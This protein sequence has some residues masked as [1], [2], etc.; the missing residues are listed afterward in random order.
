MRVLDALSTFQPAIPG[1]DAAVMKHHQRD[2]E[3]ALM[4]VL[5]TPPGLGQ[6]VRRLA[7]NCL[8]QLFVHGNTIA[9]FARV[10]E[11]QAARARPPARPL[12]RFNAPARPPSLLCRGAC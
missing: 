11:L 3:D 2:A 5:L 6:P 1:T 9:V 4:K 10:S 12:L 8:A 7:A